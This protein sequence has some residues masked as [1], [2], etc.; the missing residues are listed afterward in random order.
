VWFV[1]STASSSFPD[2]RSVPCPSFELCVACCVFV[3]WLGLQKL[4][5]HVQERT[6]T[7][8]YHM[9]HRQMELWE[10]TNFLADIS[11]RTRESRDDLK[12]VGPQ[13]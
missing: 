9:A 12:R 7:Y 4:R 10:L 1:W 2:E 6:Q 8:M 3:V 11:I 5:T 13:S